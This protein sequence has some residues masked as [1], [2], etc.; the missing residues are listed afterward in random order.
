MR[1]CRLNR[2]WRHGSVTPY[3]EEMRPGARRAAG[4][5][6]PGPGITIAFWTF[7]SN[8]PLPDLPRKLTTSQ[9]TAPEVLCVGG[10]LPLPA[11]SAAGYGKDRSASRVKPKPLW[12]SR[13]CAMG[14]KLWLG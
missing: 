8:D 9:T 7:V 3:G 2:L 10:G 11:S 1:L 12:K 4:G 13:D 14:P 5:G 6:V